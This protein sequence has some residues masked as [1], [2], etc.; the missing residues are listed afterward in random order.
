MADGV[1]NKQLVYGQLNPVD[2]P[3][4]RK[5][6]TR[7]RLDRQR[8]TSLMRESVMQV[9]YGIDSLS[10][11]GPYYAVVL[12]EIGTDNS[13]GEQLPMDSAMFHWFSG[14]E[15]K[16]ENLV[17]VRARIPELHADIPNPYQFPIN[18]P[19]F[20]N[21]VK[22][23]P[24]FVG[25]DDVV[26]TA[27][28]VIQVDFQNKTNFT[29][30]IYVSTPQ[31]DQNGMALLG[32]NATES[33]SS[34]FTAAGPGLQ[35]VPPSGDALGGSKGSAPLPSAKN[36]PQQGN[37]AAPITS[38][39]SE[40][41]QEI[42][43]LR[44]EGEIPDEL[45]DETMIL[46]NVEQTLAYK[47][48][49]QDYWR[50]MYPSAEVTITSLVRGSGKNKTKDSAHGHGIAMDITVKTSHGLLNAAQVYIGYKRMMAAGLLPQGGLGLY[51]NHENFRND[52]TH[53]PSDGYRTPGSSADVHWD[54][55]NTEN[56]LYGGRSLTGGSYDGSTS[57]LHI[58]LD[59]DGSDDL[60]TY[61][62]DGVIKIKSKDVK[63]GNPVKGCPKLDVVYAIHWGDLW[64]SEKSEELASLYG[65]GGIPK[66]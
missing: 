43:Q 47:R 29:G 37:I 17:M 12:P 23:H 40:L 45:L 51:V 28:M 52:F 9:E 4:I 19:Q 6:L 34:A 2:R 15:K 18:S 14:L 42:E 26:P 27:G 44:E 57:W 38:P 41:Q 1:N 8:F 61:R 62:Y 59:G 32:G 22:M 48:I 53:S 49:V 5:P 13:D 46:Q 10:N 50:L 21:F 31:Q 20:F 16:G 54:W 36:F 3:I 35:T 7:G 64:K 11:T 58:D 65:I 24:I 25:Y 55:R 30:P 63:N 33:P 60:A 39:N 56:M 66:L